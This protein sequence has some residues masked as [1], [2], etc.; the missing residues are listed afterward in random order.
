MW[1]QL[2]LRPLYTYTVMLAVILKREKIWAWRP[3][4]HKTRHNMY[5]DDQ[6]TSST[7]F[8]VSWSITAHTDARVSSLTCASLRPPLCQISK[9]SLRRHT[10]RFSTSCP[11]RQ[12]PPMGSRSTELDPTPASKCVW[13]SRCS[14]VGGPSGVHEINPVHWR[15]TILAGRYA[16]CVNKKIYANSNH[17]LELFLHVK[18]STVASFEVFT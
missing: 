15:L 16:V 17:A 9:T 1:G 7:C 3:Y 12:I 13:M 14:R 18:N 8:Q 2:K 11:R 4:E 10:N 6:A 5:H